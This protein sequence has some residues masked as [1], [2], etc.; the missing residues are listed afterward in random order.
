MQP[1]INGRLRLLQPD[2]SAALARAKAAAWEATDPELLELCR[3]LVVQMLD[4]DNGSRTARTV[5]TDLDAQK[6]AELGDWLNSDV[7]SPLERAALGFTEQFVLSV[8]AVSDEQ[9]E[10]LRAH[11]DDEA[12]YAFAAALYL[13]EMSERLQ[14]VS[15]SVLGEGVPV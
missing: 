9:V 5:V 6:F 7:F 13:V 12:V 14:A 3:C 4:L 11:L 8:S 1:E 10:A 15:D 2:A